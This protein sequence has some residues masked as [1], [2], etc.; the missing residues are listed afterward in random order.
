MYCI[1]LAFRLLSLTF[2]VGGENLE[3]NRFKEHRCNKGGNDS[4]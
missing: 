1:L 3:E 4:F 2:E